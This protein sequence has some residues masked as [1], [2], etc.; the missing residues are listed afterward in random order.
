M[1]SIRKKGGETEIRWEKLSKILSSQKFKSV[2]KNW[3]CFIYKCRM[4][5]NGHIFLSLQTTTVLS[6]CVWALRYTAAESLKQKK[7]LLTCNISDHSGNSEN[8]PRYFAPHRYVN[9]GWSH[10]WPM[11][12]GKWSSQSDTWTVRGLKCDVLKPVTH[13]AFVAWQRV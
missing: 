1:V 9:A 7:W 3:N 2:A 5:K 12:R 10:T 8:V 6:Q 4:K 11:S 13:E